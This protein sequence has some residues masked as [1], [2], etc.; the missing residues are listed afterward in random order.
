[1]EPNRTREEQPPVIPQNA[2]G[3]ERVPN[4]ARDYD[5]FFTA[6]A[7]DSLDLARRIQDPRWRAEAES[8]I[9]I[10]RRDPYIA[11]DIEDELYRCIAL[12]EIAIVTD[13]VNLARDIADESWR[14]RALAEIAVRTNDADLVREVTDRDRRIHALSKIGRHYDAARR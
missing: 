8:A 4:Y 1:M 9:A 3:D 2:T 14:N 12:M 6:I 13:D 5:R 10:A 11:V 7:F